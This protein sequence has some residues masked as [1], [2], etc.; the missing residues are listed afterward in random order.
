MEVSAGEPDPTTGATPIGLLLQP[1]GLI[2]R[3]PVTLTI[4]VPL[5]GTIVGPIL[6]GAA[7][8]EAL[9]VHALGPESASAEGRTTFVVEVPHFSEILVWTNIEA[10]APV[11]RVLEATPERPLLVGERFAVR[12]AVSSRDVELESLGGG[13]SVNW[14]GATAPSS[15]AFRVHSDGEKPWSVS[16]WMFEARNRIEGAAEVIAPSSGIATGD[17]QTP[18]IEE[19]YR[20]VG[21][22][23]FMLVARGEL[24]QAATL[25]IATGDR[26]GERLSALIIQAAPTFAWPGECVASGDAAASPTSEGLERVSAD[27]LVLDGEGYPL[28]QFDSVPRDA[29]CEQEHYHSDLA[30]YSVEGG[31]ATAPAP[32]GCGSGTVDDVRTVEV[33]SDAW[34]AYRRR[35]A[36]G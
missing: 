2:F 29:G 23:P 10:G 27:V 28:E 13:L 12:L 1:D 16:Y 34:A 36:G 24:T 6:V 26:A 15:G 4:D 3:E 18:L 17:G 9:V 7:G 8:P 31:T 19:E 33:G 25:T 22:G 20:C 11:V 35:L 32:G 14:G 5:N 21:P 30:V